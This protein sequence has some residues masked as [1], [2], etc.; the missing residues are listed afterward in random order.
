MRFGVAL[1]GEA[2]TEQGHFGPLLKG[3]FFVGAF[4]V[5]AHHER[6]ARTF[7]SQSG[8]KKA[9]RE[10]GSTRFTSQPATYVRFLCLAFSDSQSA[11]GEPSPLS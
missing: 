10:L 3:R 8:L 11:R 9:A 6:L 7:S 1:Q 4:R 2:A 5:R